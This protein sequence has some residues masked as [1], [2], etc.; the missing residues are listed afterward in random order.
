MNEQIVGWI[1]GCTDEHMDVYMDRQTK[2][3]MD[4]CLE[5]M[6]KSM[7]EQINGVKYECTT[8]MDGWVDG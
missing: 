5:W 1:D 2:R 6:D 7:N 3:W 8:S 4:E